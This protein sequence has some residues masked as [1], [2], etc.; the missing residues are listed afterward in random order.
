MNST[1]ITLIIVAALVIVL[2]ILYFHY[3]NLEI[4]LRKECEAQNKNIENVHDTMWKIIQQKAQ[5]SDQYR[6]AFERIYPALVAGRYVNDKGGMMKWIQED[7]PTFDTALY[8]DLM[9][10]IEVQRTYFKTAQQRMLDLIR[11]RETLIESLPAKFFISN[12]SKI[13]YEV[14]S[15]SKTKQVMDARLDDDVD[16]FSK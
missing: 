14:V 2:V 11:Q 8:E 12:K 9:Q 4:A 7:N 3:N 16:L 13:E 15:S 10:A 6:E 1:I 5:V